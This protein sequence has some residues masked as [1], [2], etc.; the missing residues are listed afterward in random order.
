M[1]HCT[2]LATLIRLNI[3]SLT[4]LPLLGDLYLQFLRMLACQFEVC[5]KYAMIWSPSIR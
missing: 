5:S 2:M 1:N 4:I 3:L